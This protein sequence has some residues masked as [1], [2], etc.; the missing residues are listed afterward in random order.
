MT[1]GRHH[2]HPW[3]RFRTLVEWSLHFAHLPDGVL[4]QTDHERRTVTLTHGLTQVERR[5]TI[6]HE[7]AHVERGAVPS[8][9]R[10][11]EER[12]CD[13]IAARRLVT[14]E[15]LADAMVWSRDEHEIADECWV[16][17]DTVRARL[18]NLTP[19]ERAHIEDRLDEAGVA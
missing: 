8:W 19:F 17:V 2:H 16:D 9:M 6:A 15:R 14:L 4:G 13:A 18:A 7:T 5:S 3:R 11:R 12:A 10:A 1:R